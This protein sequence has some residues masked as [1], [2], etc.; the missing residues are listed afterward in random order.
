MKPFN[1]LFAFAVLPISGLLACASAPEPVERIASTRAAIRS[2]E[3]VG[4]KHVPDAALHLQLAH[5]QSDHAKQLIAAGEMERANFVLMRAES[6]AEVALALARETSMQH[7][8][9]QELDKVRALRKQA[10]PGS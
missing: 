8:A 6:D 7:D 3:E 4:A 2:A 9:Q 5:E 1:P 10:T